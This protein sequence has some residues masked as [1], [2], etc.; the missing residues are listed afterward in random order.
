MRGVDNWN[1]HAL[2]YLLKINRGV[3]ACHM[4]KCL[5][6]TS[7][8]SY[9]KERDKKKKRESLDLCDY[10]L[11]CM[12]VLEFKKKNLICVNLYRT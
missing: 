6:S 12:R 9:E 8:L 4:Q 10:L 11:I 5:S 7:K 1:F 3:G 2:E